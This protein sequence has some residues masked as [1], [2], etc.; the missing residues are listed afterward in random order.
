M[1]LAILRASELQRNPSHPQRTASQRRISLRICVGM[2][3]EDN[4]RLFG[5]VG[6]QPTV[7]VSQTAELIGQ[8]CGNRWLPNAREKS[9]FFSA[10]PMDFSQMLAPPRTT[11]IFGSTASWAS[12]MV[13][14]LH[15]VL[16]QRHVA[17]LPGA[18]HLVCRSS[19]SGYGRA[20]DCRSPRA[21][22]PCGC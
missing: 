15:P 11:L 19:S 1:R 20:R 13:V 21:F 9:P 17:V 14:V 10:A 22:C 8:L 12:T 7:P 16:V 4:R 3:G 18:V 5:A 2:F 6:E